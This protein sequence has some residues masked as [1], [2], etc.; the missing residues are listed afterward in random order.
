MKRFVAVAINSGVA[1]LYGVW[2]LL[3]FAVAVREPHRIASVVKDFTQEI[4][5][6]ALESQGP[7]IP[8]TLTP[9]APAAVPPLPAKTGFL[10]PAGR[11]PI[12]I[13]AGDIVCEEPGS[14]SAGCLH[15]A[16]SDLALAQNPDAALI[17]G[18]LC[19]TP[20]ED[21]LESEFMPTWGRMF[22][23]S[24]PVPGNHD[25][26]D[27]SEVNYFDYWNGAG[28]LTGRAGERAKGYYSFD[29]GGWHILALNSQCELV[30]GCEQGSPQYLWLEQDL[31]N[32]PAKCTLAYW[33]TPV[34][35]S[36]GRGNRDMKPVFALLYDYNAELVLN[37]HHHIYERFAPQNPAGAA[38]PARGI[39]E[40]I[41]GT[42]GSS[43]N[44]IYR[45]M[46]NSE[47]RN[48]NTFGVLKLSLH[49][50]GYDWEFIPAQGKSFSDAGTGLCH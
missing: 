43:H 17:L 5:T 44:S 46:L 4:L 40:F 10:Q 18:D 8:P 2:F 39:R 34:F 7:A 25:Y 29:L 27:D 32:S 14:S 37:A 3:L 24:H 35:S 9:F 50:D 13:A 20:S 15:R 1:I 31:K 33:H 45:I 41:A 49:P 16:V 28:L 42:G 38:D 30:G 23:I 26:E 12:L 47:V 19:Q 48:A 6:N 22:S 11:D 36:S 21:C